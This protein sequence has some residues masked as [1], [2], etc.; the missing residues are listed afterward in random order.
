MDKILISRCNCVGNKRA[1]LCPWPIRFNTLAKATS[2]I[3]GCEKEGSYFVRCSG[4]DDIAGLLILEGNS[5]ITDDGRVVSGAPDPE[6]IHMA[7]SM[8]GLSNI[9]YTTFSN[10]MTKDEQE[11]NGI[12]SGGAYGSEYHRYRVLIPCR[13]TK[14][15]LSFL[16]SYLMSHFYRHEIMLADVDINRSWSQPWYFPRVPQERRFFFKQYQKKMD[17]LDIVKVI[18]ELKSTYDSEEDAIQRQKLV[19]ARNYGKQEEIVDP[20][21]RAI[22]N[23]SSNRDGF[24]ISNVLTAVLETA[25]PHMRR[26]EMKVGG[27]LRSLGF[28]KKRQLINGKPQVIWSKKHEAT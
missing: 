1:P 23:W 2:S 9:V 22:D 20:W 11:A 18:D 12:D 7:L 19:A 25:P 10:G 21:R 24:T 17:D 8:L 16:I 5:R 15:Q 26:D 14:D 6:L 13:Y 4:S 28:C 3:Q 27:I